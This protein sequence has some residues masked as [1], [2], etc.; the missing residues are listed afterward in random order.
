MKGLK[1]NRIE[2][3]EVYWFTSGISE[4]LTDDFEKVMPIVM[5]IVIGKDT[6]TGEVKTYIGVGN[7]ES[8]QLDCKMI[9]DW[10][11]K[12]YASDL[13]A[14]CKRIMEA[15]YPSLKSK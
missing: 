5:G 7:G 12:I 11:Q 15:K 9:I 13:N 1:H 14:I 8:K 2:V 4:D 3:I 10:G 6:N